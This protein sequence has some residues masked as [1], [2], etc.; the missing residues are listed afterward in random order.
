MVRAIG[1]WWLETRA[2][3]RERIVDHVTTLLWDGFS[4]LLAPAEQPAGRG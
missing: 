1:I 2:V 4:M 3:P